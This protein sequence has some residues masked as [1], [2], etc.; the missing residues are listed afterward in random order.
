[1]LKQFSL[2]F[3]VLIACY[4]G[5]N[6]RESKH[7]T[8]EFEVNAPASEVWELC[9]SLGLKNLVAR[10]LKNVVQSVQVLKG[11]GGVGTVVKTTLVPG[12]SSYTE[13]FTVIDD[14]KRVKVAQG[15]EG[16]CLA[17]G[18]SVLN[19][20]LEIIEKSQNSSIIK[21]TVSYTV[22]K[23]FQAKDPKP[24]IQKLEAM[25]QISKEYLERNN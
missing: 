22:K 20:R 18:C 11:D 23:E 13:K 1:M 3:F 12:I 19:L 14:Q 15:L 24:T 6:V 17:F 21:Y 4:V 7:I 16:D 8:K 5:V 9:R 25:I 2:V 10:K